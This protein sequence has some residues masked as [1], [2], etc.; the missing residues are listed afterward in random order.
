MLEFQEKNI[1]GLA[2]DR[3]GI[4][5]PTELVGVKVR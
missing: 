3:T 1:S 4:C 5:V 2:R